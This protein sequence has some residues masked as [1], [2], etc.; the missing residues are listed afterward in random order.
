M[1]LIVY[2]M[3]AYKLGNL[4]FPFLNSKYT[5]NDSFSVIEV[6]NYFSMWHLPQIVL[7]KMPQ[8]INFYDILNGNDK[9]YF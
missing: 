4:F 6:R 3:Y 9:L 1:C 5:L 2:E 8:V 7:E